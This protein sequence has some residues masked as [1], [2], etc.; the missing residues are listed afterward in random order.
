MFWTYTITVK[1]GEY[2]RPSDDRFLRIKD[3]WRGVQPVIH[4]SV[5]REDYLAEHDHELP[6]METLL[7]SHQKA[8]NLEHI[9]LHVEQRS[10]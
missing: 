1:T 10:K 3:T 2:I 9:S 6:N 7:E 5:S 4:Y 8:K